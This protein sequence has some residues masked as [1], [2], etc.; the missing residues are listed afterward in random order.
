MSFASLERSVRA[1]NAHPSS[2]TST[3]PI[4]FA[5]LP[6]I[7]DAYVPVKSAQSQSST[8]ST[9]SSSSAKKST[10]TEETAA[11]DPA[12]ALY[13]VPEFV[14]LGR[15]FRT[16]RES[17]LTESEMEYVVKCIKHVFDGHIVLQFSILNTIDDQRL[18]NVRVDVDGYDDGYEIEHVIPAAV[19]RYGE[20]SNCFVSLVK[21]TDH[22]VPVCLS[23]ELKFTVVQVDPTT[24]EVEGDEDGYEEDYAL[25]E[26]DLN[27]ND[28]MAKVSFPD[29]RQKWE[30]V[31][32]EGEVIEKYSLQFKKLSE[33]LKAVVDFLGMQPCDN[34]GVISSND[35]SK[36]SHTLHLSGMFIG[37]IT[38]LVRA[39]LQ[40]DEST[41]VILKMA[42]RSESHEISSLVSDCI[43]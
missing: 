7:E 5:S 34:T 36:K 40:L 15:P 17:A 24:G 9:S 30:E 37:N 43:Q 3:K 19:A 38:V 25:E 12:S 22:P 41:G 23:C 31:G 35:A 14:E 21:T 20:E 4:T 32:N 10:T 26:L 29:F 42:V 1:Y 33:A 11:V 13:K 18:T 6:I 39:Q 16:T 27:T 8:R 2:A 28:Y